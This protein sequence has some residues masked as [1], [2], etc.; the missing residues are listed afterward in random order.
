MSIQLDMLKR[1]PDVY[2]KDLDSNIGKLFQI[3][4]GEY[5]EIKKVFESIQNYRDIDQAK[6][7]PLD[8][9]GRNVLE[10]RGD[11]KDQDYR[12]FIKTKI[13][14]NLSAGDIETLND[15][16]P[17]LLGDNFIEV[18]EAWNNDR[19]NNEPAAISVKYLYE[20]NIEEFLLLDG[21]TELNGEYE[22]I[23]IKAGS[24]ALDFN[25]ETQKSLKS[26]VATGI[27]MY[28]T[29]FVPVK[30]SFE[31]RKDVKINAKLNITKNSFDTLQQDITSKTIIKVQKPPDATINGI[32]QLN[33][34]VLLDG[35][36]PLK[37]ING[38]YRLDGRVY[39]DGEHP[40]LARNNAT[41]NIYK[42]GQLVESEVI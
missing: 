1:L 38:I 39:L 42:D 14:A 30:T 21:S 37:P 17:V 23:G 20:D 41:I 27:K 29:A 24:F 32:Y 34:I 15:V 4:A 22:L 12:N 31:T 7:I 28:S 16:Y 13:R 10:S 19:L 36:Q 11:K 6:G 25:E 5:E 2:N 40:P 18:S 33:G 8:R 9:I 26:I 3:V 35:G